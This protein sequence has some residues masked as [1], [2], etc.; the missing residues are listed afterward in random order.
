MART[1]DDIFAD[2]EERD[3]YD[4][5]V[6]LALWR[7]FDANTRL[8]KMEHVGRGKDPIDAWMLALIDEVTTLDKYY[9]SESEADK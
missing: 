6:R 7:E 5:G 9:L 8:R 2:D 3:A 4:H 1:A